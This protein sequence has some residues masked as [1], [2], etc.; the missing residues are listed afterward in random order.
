[1]ITIGVS[2]LGEREVQ[3]F[4]LG[5][6]ETEAFSRKDTRTVWLEFLHSLVQRGL[7]GVQLVTSDAHEGL[8][9]AIGQ[10]LTGASWQRCRVHFMR[11]LLCHIPRADQ[12]MVATGLRTIFAQ[13]HQEAAR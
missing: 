8:K 6:S 2:E 4:A 9:A 13:P 1:M 5:A 3:G 11:N 7:A 12:A 10:V